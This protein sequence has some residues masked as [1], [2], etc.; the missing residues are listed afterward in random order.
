[1]IGINNKLF[2]TV[3]HEKEVGIKYRTW[4]LLSKL[5]KEIT[6]ITKRER[7]PNYWLCVWSL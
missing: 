7:E 1:L 4:W 6:E 3:N 5:P 2:L